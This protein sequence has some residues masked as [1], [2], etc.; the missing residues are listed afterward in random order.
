[1][2]KLALA[3]TVFALLAG[4]RTAPVGAV[5]AAVANIRVLAIG[6]NAGNQEANEIFASGDLAGTIDRSMSTFTFNSMTPAQLRAS[7]DVLLFTWSGDPSLNADW[8][9]RLLPY[10]NLG[11]N[12]IWE[13][14]NNLPDLAP[15]LT[16]V[17]F[18]GSGGYAFVASVP[19]L[20]DGVVA[21]FE[22]HHIG[23]TAFTA[24]FQP[25][26]TSFGQLIS[27]YGEFPSGARMLVNGPDQ[28]YHADR[29][30]SFPY[31]NQYNYFL[32]QFR[33]VTSGNPNTLGS[34]KNDV[35]ALITSG[36]LSTS[37][38]N[39]LL[40]ILTSAELRV[41]QGRNAAAV[42]LLRSFITYVQRSTLLPADKTALINKAN[43]IIATL[44]GP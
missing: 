26:I 32:N 35:Q 41:T 3:F 11:G 28:D 5:P 15:A 12:V 4:L 9:T 16:L 1:M 21:A 34:L 40:S 8:N 22:N 43:A 6:G 36:A 44:S 23:V 13:D 7:Y 19:G 20:T 38:G 39:T 2:R 10:L 27:V 17:N 18:D 31:D 42:T 30:G 14:N 24:P 37:Y 33:W 25:L 29:G